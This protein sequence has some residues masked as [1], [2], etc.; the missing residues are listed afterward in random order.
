MA[1]KPPSPL[2]RHHG[3]LVTIIQRSCDLS[4]ESTGTNDLADLA[5]RSYF[6]ETDLCSSGE[7]SRHQSAGSSHK[8]SLV[9]RVLVDGCRG[10]GLYHI[11]VLDQLTA[12]H[13]KDVNDYGAMLSHS[14]ERRMHRD[15]VAIDDDALEVQ[16]QAWKL[17]DEARDTDANAVDA[18]RD[19]LA[20]LSVG[21]SE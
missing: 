21:R 5:Q 13:A 1:P 17:L 4:I 20:M 12:L 18:I 14:G 3:E 7:A 6:I 15:E 16:V 9:H 19:L 2:A 11:P 8:P 10:N